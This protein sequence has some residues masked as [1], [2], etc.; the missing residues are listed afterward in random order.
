MTLQIGN[1]T[2]AINR[3]REHDLERR[4]GATTILTPTAVQGSTS[5]A[6]VLF[7]TLGGVLRPRERGGLGS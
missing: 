3:I 2:A 6:R 5:P 4:R 1:T 7:T